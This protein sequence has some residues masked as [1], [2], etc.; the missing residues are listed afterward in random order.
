VSAELKR[1]KIT[2]SRRN[3]STSAHQYSNLCKYN[4]HSNQ[5][6]DA[7]TAWGPLPV[8]DADRHGFG[9]LKPLCLPKAEFTF[10]P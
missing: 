2:I 10:P 4:A 6:M 3:E 9:G 7:D 5:Y 8:S 1:S